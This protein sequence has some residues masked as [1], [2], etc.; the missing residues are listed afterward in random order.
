M[1]DWQL[2]V[3]G[4][5]SG[6]IDTNTTKI[7]DQLFI[8]NIQ[9]GLFIRS[10]YPVSISRII[11]PKQFIQ[12]YL[13]SGICCF[14]QSFELDCFENGFRTISFRLPQMENLCFPTTSQVFI[15]CW[16]NL[17]KRQYENINLWTN[18]SFRLNY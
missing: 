15:H 3:I 8:R 2:F 12:N 1:Q 4:C 7:L 16:M 13:Y 9:S 17:L 18:V 14:E 10:V 6:F 11:Y 5:L